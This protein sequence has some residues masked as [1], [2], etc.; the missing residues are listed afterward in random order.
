MFWLLQEDF[1]SNEP[2]KE[3]AQGITGL[4]HGRNNAL[5]ADDSSVALDDVR[6]P[7]Q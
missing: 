2:M 3:G 5:V 1:G 6:L 7:V 4:L